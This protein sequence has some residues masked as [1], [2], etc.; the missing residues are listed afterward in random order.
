MSSVFDYQTPKMCV[1]KTCQLFGTMYLSTKYLCS[2]DCNKNQIKFIKSDV[3]N[4]FGNCTILYR[5]RFAQRKLVSVIVLDFVIRPLRSL[6]HKIVRLDSLGDASLSAIR[7]VVWTQFFSARSRF[8][9]LMQQK[10]FA[11]SCHRPLCLSYTGYAK[12]S[13]SYHPRR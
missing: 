9:V 12:R 1:F 7:L 4:I 6:S 13:Y 11:L 8:I 3:C 10:L 5:L 2:S